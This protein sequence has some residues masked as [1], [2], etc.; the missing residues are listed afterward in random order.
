MTT[1]LRTYT[2][3]RG[4]MDDFVQ[5]WLAGVYPL[6][7]KHGF[8]IDGAW[9]NKDRSEFIWLLSYDGDDWKAKDDAYY[10]SPERA[11]VNPDPRQF[12]ARAEHYFITP[13]LLT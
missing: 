6:R 1:Q 13:V 2:I 7:R 5:A 3:N 4:K 8:R 9:V 11:A 12:I 10:A